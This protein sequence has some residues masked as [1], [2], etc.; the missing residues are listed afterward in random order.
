MSHLVF[1]EHHPSWNQHVSGRMKQGI[2]QLDGIVSKLTT[3]QR[4][5]ELF[6]SNSPD[7]YIYFASWLEKRL[8][9]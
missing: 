8:M 6:S 9:V 5:H 7:W 1:Q 2:Q 3:L 4:P